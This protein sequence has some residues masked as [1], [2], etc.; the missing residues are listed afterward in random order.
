[1][2]V[3][4]AADFEDFRVERPDMPPS[5]ESDLEP[6]VRLLAE[7]KWPSRLHATYDQTISRALDVFEEVNKDM[8]ASGSQLV[9]RPRRDDQRAQYRSHRRARRRHRGPAPDDVPGRIFHRTLWSEGG[10]GDTPNQADDDGGRPARRRG[11]RR[12]ARRKLQ[13][14]GLRSRGSSR[15]RRWVAQTLYPVR[16]RLDRETALRLGTEKNTWFSNEVGKKAQ[17][18]EKAVLADLALLSGRLFQRC[19]K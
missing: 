1:M 2:L 3:Y 11:H 13:P 6:V 15:E 8:P 14:V 4:S 18:Q 16:N 5:M 19:R 17:I 10:R 7:R 12:D 9:L